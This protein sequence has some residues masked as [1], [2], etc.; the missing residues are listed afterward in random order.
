MHFK[1]QAKDILVNPKFTSIRDVFWFVVITLVIHYSYRYWA[2]DLLY[3]PV[4]G[5]MEGFQRFMVDVMFHQS[6]WVDQHLLGLN[7]TLEGRTMFFSNGAGISINASCSGDKQLLQLALLLLIFPGRWWPKLWMIPLGLL[8]VHA[9]NIL[10]IVLLS[11]VAVW[12]P[13]WI[14]PAHDTILR[15][16]FYVV[17]FAVWVWY[18]KVSRSN[19]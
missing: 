7:L 11:L 4:G 1:D 18:V 17:I 16:I 10:R 12:N 13:E 3:W 5:L 6:V 15:A 2:Q 8:L 19:S 9:T 14:K